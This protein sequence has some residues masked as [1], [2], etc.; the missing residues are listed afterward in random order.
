[1]IHF[2]ASPLGLAFLKGQHRLFKKAKARYFCS[3]YAKQVACIH[4]I[5]G[6]T[7]M[8]ADKLPKGMQSV[9]MGRLLRKR[10]PDWLPIPKG[11]PHCGHAVALVNNS[12]IYGKSYGVWP[13]AWKCDHCDAYVGVHADSV[14][15]QGA[16]AGRELHVMRHR[17][18][19]QLVSMRYAGMMSPAEARERLARM[20]G[21]TVAACRI[22]TFSEQQCQRALE[23]INQF[24]QE[25]GVCLRAAA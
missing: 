25:Y 24:L 12:V 21:M 14:Y 23:S 16:L 11:C 22:A 5:V 7:E 9:S 2:F 15:P 10:H 4:Q 6:G 1:M 13:Y 19:E 17:V 20:L 3:G 8:K 18:A